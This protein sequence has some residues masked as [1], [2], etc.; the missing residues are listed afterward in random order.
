MM[1]YWTMGYAIMSLATYRSFLQ[2]GLMERAAPNGISDTFGHPWTVATLPCN[3]GRSQSPAS[4]F[5]YTSS[6]M[7][8]KDFEDHFFWLG[9]YDPPVKILHRK[10]EILLYGKHADQSSSARHVGPFGKLLSILAT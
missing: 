2:I 8:V 5:L 1:P 9:V 4:G 10:N 6:C 3:A 7:Q